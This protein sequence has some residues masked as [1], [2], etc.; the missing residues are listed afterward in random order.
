MNIAKMKWFVKG[1]IIY[2]F[3][4]DLYICLQDANR[5]LTRPCIQVLETSLREPPFAGSHLFGRAFV[6]QGTT[7]RDPILIDDKPY[8]KMLD[9]R[10]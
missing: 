5:P 6:C 9:D 4:V 7:E 2:G 8:L 3:A 1:R 10:K